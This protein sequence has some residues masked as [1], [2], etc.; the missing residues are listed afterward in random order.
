MGFIMDGLD[1]EAYDRK[2]SDWQLIRRIFAYFRPQ[3]RRMAVVVAGLV[4]YSAVTTLTPIYLSRTLDRAQLNPEAF[5]WRVSALVIIVLGVLGW[6]LNALQRWNT[7]V[8]I[9]EVV[10]KIRR[11]AFDAVTQRDLSFYDQFASGR[12][13]SRVTSDTQAFSSTVELTTNLLSQVALIV[14]LLVYLFLGQCHP[15]AGDAFDHPVH[16][17]GGVGVPR[18]CPPYHH[19]HPSHHGNRQRPRSRNCDGDRR[20][21]NIP[22]GSHDL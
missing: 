15:R 7:F 4:L 3:A 1:A 17:G 19:R 16:C 8:A 21:K 5:D 13:V 22:Q 10:L 18:D 6:L 9:G 2:Y 12:I 20:G 14:F 11:D